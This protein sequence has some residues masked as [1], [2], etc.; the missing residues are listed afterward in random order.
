M[1]GRRRRQSAGRRSQAAADLDAAARRQ[2]QNDNDASGSPQRVK[3]DPGRGPRRGRP[4]GRPEM[5]KGLERYSV[6]L[7]GGTSQSAE[8]TALL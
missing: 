6:S 2:T 8:L 5:R 1:T 3:N 7:S 4:G